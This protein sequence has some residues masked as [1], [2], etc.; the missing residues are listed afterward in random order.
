MPMYDKNDLLELKNK[1]KRRKRIVNITLFLILAAAGAAVFFTQELWMPKLRGIGEQYTTIV[2]DGR[3]AEGNF[4]IE[5]NGGSSYQFDCTKDCAVVLCDAYIYFYTHEG[6]LIK[7][8]QHAYTNAVMN[9][10]SDRVL[11]FENGGSDLS[12]EDRNGV[13]YSKTMDE[14]IMF[15]RLSKNGCAAVV[16]AS[17]NY[18]C[19]FVVYDRRGEMIYERK[20]NELVNDISFN[21]DGSGC[22]ISYIYAE[23]GSLH[24]SMQEIS[25]TEKTEIWASP[26]IDTT[27]I[28]VYDCEEGAFVL[29]MDACGY[30]DNNGQISSFYQYDGSLEGGSGSGGKAAVIMNSDDRRKYVMVLFN[31]GAADPVVLNFESPLIDVYVDGEL[32]YVMTQDSVLAY[33]FKGG[34]RSTAQISDSYTGFVRSGNYIFLKSFNKIDR[35]NYES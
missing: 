5:I 3:L 15:A 21:D 12:V 23:N 31:G 30:V 2:N 24:T 4:P 32:A 27:G 16:T 34:L 19:E 25:F 33:D 29:G 35:I 22:V 17:E 9:V 13:L 28:D 14:N 10:V 6:G 18:D 26:G 1:K 20:C 11:I 7:R 8:R